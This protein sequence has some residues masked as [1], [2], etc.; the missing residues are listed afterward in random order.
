METLFWGGERGGVFGKKG[1]KLIAEN[2]PGWVYRP[3]SGYPAK[4]SNF[5]CKNNYQWDYASTKS[6]IKNNMKRE[7]IWN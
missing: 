1:P 4:K 2:A 3:D 5:D 7:D 6:L